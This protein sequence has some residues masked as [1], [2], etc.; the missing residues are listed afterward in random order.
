[1]TLEFA[2]NQSTPATAT[3]DCV[4][5][6]VFA[7]KSLSPAAKAVDSA[8][9]GRLQALVERGDVSGK[10]GSTALLHDMPGV[11]SAE[12]TSELQSLMRISYAVYCLQK[13]TTQP[14]HT[15]HMS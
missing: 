1:M 4:I 12:H 10:T 14:T 6:G 11:R 8:S 2:L 15:N 9:G 3:T 13:Q 5:V 7:D